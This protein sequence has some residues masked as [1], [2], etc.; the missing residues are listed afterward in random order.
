[1]RQT[2]SNTFAV[3][4]YRMG[5]NNAKRGGDVWLLAEH[6]GDAN[7]KSAVQQALLT[8]PL[9]NPEGAEQHLVFP[10]IPPQKQG[11]KV[12][13]LNATSDAGVPVYY[14]VREG[15]AEVEGDGLRF[16]PIPPRA[17]FPVKVTVVAWQY[18][19]SLAPKLK[20][21]EPVERRFIITQ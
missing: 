9:R 16:T 1:V 6:P 4:F 3:S 19:R 20:S 12:V 14:Y 13:K 11:A 2:G 17:A 8:I 10:E 21:A 15:P 5:M 18:G 7:Y